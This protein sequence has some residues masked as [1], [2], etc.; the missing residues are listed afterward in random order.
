MLK[1]TKSRLEA[2]VTQKRKGQA[3]WLNERSRVSEEGMTEVTEAEQRRQRPAEV[4]EERVIEGA[5]DMA[6]LLK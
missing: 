4:T 5:I 6:P 1:A 3:S 2:K